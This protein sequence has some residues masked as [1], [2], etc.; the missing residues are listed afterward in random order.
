MV[1]TDRSIEVSIAA[2]FVPDRAKF[3][4]LSLD[5]I[6]QWNCPQIKV[7]LVTNDMALAQDDAVAASVKQLA[8]AGRDVTFDLA[9]GLA[10]PWHLTWWHKHRLEEW[11]EHASADD[12][13]CYM[14]DDIALP[15]GAMDYFAGHLTAAK[16]HGLIPG[17][18]RYE[19]SASQR[20]I[21]TDFRS[22]QVIEQSHLVDVQG[23]PFVPLQYPYWAGFML[24]RELASEYLQSP[25]S[26]IES[27]DAQ[28]QSRGHS[29]RVQSAWGLTYH[30]VPKAMPSR[31]AVPV[32]DLLKP[33]D[34][35]LVWHTPNNYSASRSHGFGTIPI[36]QVFAR[37][38]VA[39]QISNLALA[40]RRLGQRIV[41]K[42]AQMFRDS[43]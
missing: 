40:V 27:A 36:E 35:C 34:E 26:N 33:L 42:L 30:H 15:A 20:K 8:L 32:N 12:L 25:W 6:N 2:H 23:V 17:F 29:C 5:A 19:M 28:P 22:H 39:A 1:Q 41:R 18:L 21:S 38:G 14:E 16:S 10:H 43:D 11:V 3:L 9:K 37:A 31:I 4:A 13:F 7:V 24:D